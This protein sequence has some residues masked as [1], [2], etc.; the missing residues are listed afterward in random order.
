MSYEKIFSIL[1]VDRPPIKGYYNEEN[2]RRTEKLQD[3]AIKQ[4]GN[5][6][7]QSHRVKVKIDYYGGGKEDI[8]NAEGGIHDALNKI[9]FDDDR[10]LIYASMQWHLVIK[11]PT[12]Y[13]IDIEFLSPG[14]YSED[15]ELEK[16]QKLL[17]KN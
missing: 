9:A 4:L 8:T 6:K 14:M 10:D 16:Q 1:V 13:K 5:F 2:K 17:L 3:E 15:G 12:W 11:D 7:P